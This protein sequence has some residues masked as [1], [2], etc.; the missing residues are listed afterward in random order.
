M[1]RKLKVQKLKTDFCTIDIE[2]DPQGNVLD[3]GLFDGNSY[4]VFKDWSLCLT[5]I[6]HCSTFIR[7]YRTIWAHNGGRWDYL[8][9]L[10]DL[11]NSKQEI[12]VHIYENNGSIIFL[13]MYINSVK[14]NFFDSMKI[15]K[16]MSLEKVTGAFS[17][18]FQ[19]VKINVLPHVL[20]HR[21]S[22]AYYVYLEGDCRSLWHALVNFGYMIHERIAPV[23]AIPATIGSLALKCFR[24][25]LADDIETSE[26]FAELHAASRD[27]YHGG[28]TRV[29]QYGYHKD[30][31]IYDVNSMYPYVMANNKFPL[32]ASSAMRTR[33]YRKGFGI[34]LCRVNEHDKPVKVFTAGD[35]RWRHGFELDLLDRSEFQVFDGYYWPDNSCD[36]LFREFI[37]KC[38]NIRKESPA[39]NIIGKFLANNLYGKFAQKSNNQR[40]ATGSAR[41]ILESIKDSES[42]EPLSD[43]YDVWKISGPEFEPKHAFPVYSAAITSAAWAYL[44]RLAAPH[45]A[46]WV[47][48][49]TDSI[50]LTR[51]AWPGGLKPLELGG[52]KVEFEN[53]WGVYAGKKLYALQSH[54]AKFSKVRA[55]GVSLSEKHG[56]PLTAEI[57]KLLC[58]GNMIACKYE[59]S[60]TLREVLLRGEKPCR[61][62][63]TRT[64]TLRQT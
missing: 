64:K 26:N 58:N 10:Y 24:T 2:N 17:P 45:S 29:L 62:K 47:Y 25:G 19:K 39:L 61:I 38:W 41:K 44:Y 40:V 4:Y 22:E 7:S 56:A 16:D 49:D 15:F 37:L 50:H 57:I 3:I 20:K 9:M 11:L 21:N 42:A 12:P 6:I 43:D 53:G 48:C 46:S 30:I 8:S 63:L 59:Q 27:S 31:W 60:A 52:L 33:E 51:P 23:G 34:W 18:S 28:V 35:M 5:H 1:I 36:Y 55:K 14:I 54:D 32:Q 13:T